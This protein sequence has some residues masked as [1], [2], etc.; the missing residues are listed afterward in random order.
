MS[1]KN[2]SKRKNKC[3]GCGT[4]K[5]QHDFAA[6]GKYCEGPEEHDPDNMDEKSPVGEEKT[7][8]PDPGDK[9]DTLL[10]VIRAL[11]SQVETLQLEQQTLRDTVTELKDVRAKI[12]YSID[13][14]LN[15]Y[16]GHIMIYLFQ[17]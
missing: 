6:M 7:L 3:S 17:K 5:E 10:Q 8:A 15:F 4:P 14:F 12:F 16:H 1:S 11:S 2:K 9:Q 13:F